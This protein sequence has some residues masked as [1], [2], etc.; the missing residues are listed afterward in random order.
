[1]QNPFKIAVEKLENLCASIA[2]QFSPKGTPSS[3]PP[4]HKPRAGKKKDTQE[5]PHA[6][7]PPV[8][9]RPKLLPFHAPEFSWETFESFFCDFLAARPEL[10]SQDGTPCR[11]ATTYLYGRR[12]DSQHGIDIRAE[13]SNG[14]VWVFQCKHYKTWGPKDTQDAIEKCTYS[15]DRKFLLVTRPVSPDTREVVGKK[16]GWVLWD[17]DDISRE[18]F[19]RLSASEAARLLYTSFGPAWPKELLGLPGLGPFYSAE[20]KFA[21]FVEK[22]RTFHHRLALVGRE[23]WLQT[24]DD[25]IGNERHR[26][27]L[28]CGRGGLGKSRILRE[29]GRDFS[30][31]RKDWT[32]RFVSDSPSDFGPALD[33]CSRPL[34]LVFDD[35]HRLDEVRRALFSE[36]PSRKDVKLV[37]SL[38]PGPVAQVEAEL[39]DAGFDVTQ[40]QR[41]EELKRLSSEQAL[42][43]AEAA[44]GVELALH[45]RLRLRD[46]SR[47]C[48]LLAVLAAELLKSGAL[49]DRDLDN[50]AEFRIHVF[51]GLLQQAKPVEDRF[52]SAKTADFLRLIAVLAPVK[53]DAE[54][55][56]RTAAFLGGETHPNHITDILESLDNVG[57]LLTTGAGIRVTPDLLSDH[58]SFTACYDKHG[59]DTTFTERVLQHFSP[60]QFPRLMQHLAEAEWRALKESDS[61]QSIVEPLWQWFLD[62]FRRSSFHARHEQLKQWAN[63]AHLQARRTLE[64]AQL[65]L[66]LQDAPPTENAWFRTRDWDCHAHVLSALPALLKPLAKNHPESV[67]SC[68][69]ILWQIGRNL[70]P[71]PLNA[72]GHP[73]VTIGEIANFEGGVF[74]RVQREVLRWL[75]ALL[76]G[77]EWTSSTNNPT[78]LL[79][80]MLQPF[81]T[82]SIEERWSTGRTFHWRSLPVHI[83]NTAEFRDRVLEICRSILARKSVPLALAVLEVLEHAIRRA[84]IPNYKVTPE[85]EEAWLG[86]R[87]KALAVLIDVRTIH[88]SPIVHYKLRK[89]LLHALQYDG[90]ELRADCRSLFEAIPDTLELRVLRT[91]LGDYWNEFDRPSKDRPKDWQEEAKRRW[92]QFV[93]S[94]V[95]AMLEAFPDAEWLLARLETFHSELTSLGFKPDFSMVFRSIADRHPEF[96]LDLAKHL[97]GSHAHPLG[98][99]LG[100]LVFAPTASTLEQRLALCREA[101][102]TGADELTA[103]AIECFAWWRREGVLPAEAWQLVGNVAEVAS[104][105]V[106]GAVTRFVHLNDD[107][108]VEADWRLLA[109]LPVDAK[110]LWV[111]HE[112]LGRAADLLEKGMIP[113]AEIAD[114][115]LAKLD[116]I[117][118]LDGHEIERGIAQFA[119]HF[120]GKM[121]LLVWRRHQF[122]RAGESN[123]ETVPYD[124]DAVNFADVL[125]DPDAAAVVADL[126]RRLIDGGE[127]DY[128]EH[129]VL[130]ISVMQSGGNPEPHLL[131]LLDIASTGEQLNRLA[132]FAKE[133]HSWPI[134]LECSEFTQKLL[135][136]ARAVSSGCHQEIFREL[137]SF[138]GSR[139]FGSTE[140]DKEWKALLEAVESMAG[141]FA[142]DPELGPLYAAA[143]KHEREWIADMRKSGIE[144]ERAFEDEI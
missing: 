32:L 24:L 116:H 100:I 45:Y 105:R 46:L 42:E 108:P 137:L 13:M 12:G 49:A 61:A 38:R 35:A 112:L 131:Q 11:I 31:R 97:I 65:S 73:I 29:W 88:D 133:R 6:G 51:N 119:E 20:A 8:A 134:V 54:F 93:R 89:V 15:A 82:T 143:A 87:H 118:S 83:G 21:P 10:I 138:P 113:S 72:Q 106:A 25:F 96:A 121:F 62:R 115:V 3:E 17:A 90:T 74:P 57:L 114:R 34:V 124:F 135:M 47:D 107:K 110:S 68:L 132:D 79:K 140:P 103:G 7:P 109:S 40:I 84:Q 36:L 60:D 71:P 9:P 53:T 94:T 67:S 80:Q 22:G 120:P 48:P 43:L 122:K 26:V 52:G 128:E 111:T 16:A 85:F 23:D 81:F 2:R 64:L 142:D 30:N 70:P 14:E 37:L 126:E 33:A 95:D 91:V 117:Q 102:S 141:R 50:T 18:F 136:K 77:D 86:E 144:R 55:L 104:A 78:W 44:L 75:Q 123:L 130:R 5:T 56:N 19:A 69:D 1:M 41:P 63:I 76:R 92:E 99:G 139:G 101:V 129:Q 58:L 125:A 39:V 4:K 59:H 28:L 98:W 27:F 127:M 66:Q